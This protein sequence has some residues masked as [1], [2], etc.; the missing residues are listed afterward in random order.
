MNHDIK[1]STTTGEII[2]KR[3]IWKFPTHCPFCQ[4]KLVQEEGQVHWYDPNPSCPEQ[5]YARLRHATAKGAL[6]WDGMGEAQIRGFIADGC[7]TLS[8]VVASEGKF[9]KTAALKKFKLERERIKT[10]PLWRKLA[11]LGIEDVGQTSSKELAQKYRSIIAISE[12]SEEE[13]TGMLGP[14]ATASL[15]RFILDN[16]EEIERLY[17]L[18]FNFEEEGQAG[19]L[20]GVTIVITGTLLSGK[21]DQVSAKI[22]KAGGLT[23]GSVSKSTNY[24]VV[25][26]SPGANKV[27]GA[28]RLGVEMITEEKL[29][30]LLGEKF[31]LADVGEDEV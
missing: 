10:V 13:L 8:D 24:L 26:E 16:A 5:V 25:G 19:K 3:K 21:R 14:V 28:K 31:E 23:K 2:L 12:A 18:G 17:S 6:D 1:L 22:E 9:L 4:T 11:A 15:R 20:S 7:V 27:A 30:E 29:Y